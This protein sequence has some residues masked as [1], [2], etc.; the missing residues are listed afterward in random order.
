ME[1]PAPSPESL[2]LLHRTL[3]GEALMT[4]F[5]LANRAVA[6]SDDDG[7]ILAVNESWIRLLGYTRDD[8]PNLSAHTISAHP[9]PMHVDD[10]YAHLLPGTEF[11]DTAWL[12]CKDG[13]KGS[14]RYRALPATIAGLSVVVTITEDISSFQR[15]GI[16]RG[17]DG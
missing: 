3:L 5:D 7:S 1:P 14:I 17:P 6:V 10:V 11:T 15:T 2:R 13:G 16:G 12:K 8:L 9:E 4:A